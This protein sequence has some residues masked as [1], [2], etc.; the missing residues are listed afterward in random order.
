ML[1]PP[2]LR[3][4]FLRLKARDF[5]HPRGG[6]IHCFRKV[7]RFWNALCPSTIIPSRADLRS[8]TIGWNG[9]PFGPRLS[10]ALCL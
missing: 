7:A 6:D 3:E 5:N 9:K 2:G 4:I 1:I 10:L 8:E